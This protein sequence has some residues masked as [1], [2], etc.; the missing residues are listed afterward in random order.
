[1]PG[2][3]WRVMEKR[4]LLLTLWPELQSVPPAET[5][6]KSILNSKIVDKN[7]LFS[8]SL[9]LTQY[10]SVADNARDTVLLHVFASSKRKE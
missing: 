5:N 4:K 10:L 8:S 2:P 1:M 9:L 6:G 7:I 3:D